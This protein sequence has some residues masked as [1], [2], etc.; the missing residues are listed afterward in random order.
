MQAFGIKF[1]HRRPRLESFVAH[2]YASALAFMAELW[3][4]GLNGL[5]DRIW[6]DTTP[7]AFFVYLC[8]CSRG[9]NV[10][11]AVRFLGEK[12]WE[13]NFGVVLVDADGEEYWDY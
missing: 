6:F 9:S 8:G 4:C 2:D 1:E 12:R 7:Q 3:A 10:H 5:V 13:G 11:K